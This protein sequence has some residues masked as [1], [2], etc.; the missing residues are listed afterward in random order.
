MHC[1][2]LAAVLAGGA[3]LSAAYSL[4]IRDV[5]LAAAQYQS[6][7]SSFVSCATEVDCAQYNP[8]PK[9]SP[10]MRCK[11]RAGTTMPCTED[12][13]CEIKY[14]D[15][16]TTVVP[17]PTETEEPTP[18]DTTVP[19][20]TGDE[21]PV[22]PG[23]C[24][25]SVNQKCYSSLAKAVAAAPSG[26]T[27]SISS[28]ITVGAEVA[29]SKSL[30]F[31]GTK[32][33][34]KVTA[35]FSKKTA[36]I[37]RPT[38]DGQKVV[39]RNLFF[40][41]TGGYAS[42]LRTLELGEDEY[43]NPPTK[44]TAMTITNCVFQ[45]FRQQARGGSAVFVG[46]PSA[47]TVEGSTFQD[48]VVENIPTPRW[49][50]GGALWVADLEGPAVLRNSVFRNNKHQFQ[51]GMGGAFL[52]NWAG[53]DITIDGCTFENNAASG[54][55]AVYVGTVASGTTTRVTGSKFNKNKAT[56]LGWG[57]RG[58]A[59]WVQYV[60]GTFKVDGGSVFSGNTASQDRG[61]AIANNQVHPGGVVSINGKFTSNTCAK[62]AAVWDSLSGTSAFAKGAKLTMQGGCTF[63]GNMGGG[64]DLLVRLDQSYNGKVEA[65]YQSQWN[66]Q[67]VTF[68]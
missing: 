19:T 58:G 60:E 7:G 35:T 16:T 61:A 53:S 12:Y 23:K 31:A 1:I 68:N 6:G 22:A 15:L 49:E 5:P 38:G 39:L 59:M 25:I 52:A 14:G 18:T 62:G 64:K 65:L 66:G 51:H 3:S 8:D 41:S 46:M 20:A 55:G 40:T 30:T 28:D 36:A 13:C 11:P 54:G 29:F 47:L 17:E 67:T 34:P 27:V 37:L 21:P 57:S 4:H 24:A 33:Q 26:A 44:F 56:E 43:P 2:R 63:S 42:A 45:G 50:G 9:G 32:G 10:I 48:N